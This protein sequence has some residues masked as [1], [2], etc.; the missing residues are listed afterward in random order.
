MFI[1]GALVVGGAIVAHDNHSDI[2][3][4]V[5]TASITSIAMLIWSLK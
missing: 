3:I 2:V 5:D 4:I 1:A